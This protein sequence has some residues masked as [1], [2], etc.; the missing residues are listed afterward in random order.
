MDNKFRRIGI[1]FSLAA[2][3]VTTGCATATGEA[4]SRYRLVTTPGPRGT[5]RVVEIDP[6]AESS[7]TT[8]RRCQAGAARPDRPKY[9]LVTTPGPRG[10]TRAVRVREADAA[11]R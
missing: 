4:T 5:T 9:R 7:G 11:C 3:A 10:V 8:V 1:V 6:A 2:L